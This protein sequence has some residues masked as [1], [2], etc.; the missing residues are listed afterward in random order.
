MM[1]EV[2]VKKKGVRLVVIS[3]APTMDNDHL[4]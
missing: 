2:A 4:A 3:I 1:L